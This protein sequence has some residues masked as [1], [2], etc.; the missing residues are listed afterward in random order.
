MSPKF[1]E[2]QVKRTEHQC[3]IKKQTFFIVEPAAVV[4]AP[5]SAHS[6]SLQVRCLYTLITCIYIIIRRNL[7]PIIIAHYCNNHL[8][9]QSFYGLDLV[10]VAFLSQMYSS[11]KSLYLPSVLALEADPAHPVPLLK[12][13][14]HSPCS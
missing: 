13:H 8:L 14:R 3:I 9:A 12:V 1:S 7:I 4:I 11:P 5:P 2:S 6:D 10:V